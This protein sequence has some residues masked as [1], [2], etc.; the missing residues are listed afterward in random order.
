MTPTSPAEIIEID[1]HGVVHAVGLRYQWSCPR[2]QAILETA[3]ADLM[4]RCP[5]GCVS[6]HEPHG[7][8]MWPWTP[9][10]P[11]PDPPHLQAFRAES[12]PCQI[13]L[14]ETATELLVEWHNTALGKSVFRDATEVLIEMGRLAYRRAM[15][16][17][18]YDDPGLTL[19]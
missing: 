10:I 19:E 17:P 3:D 14:T 2:C 18:G 5:S 15:D 1:E 13:W 11:S 16:D 9:E 4:P 6:P 8:Q 7:V 12:L